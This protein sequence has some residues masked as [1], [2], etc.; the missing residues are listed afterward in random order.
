MIIASTASGA[1]IE[2][3]ELMRKFPRIGAV[4]KPAEGIRTA[5]SDPPT[6]T[7]L[8][9]VGYQYLVETEQPTPGPGEQVRRGPNQLI[10]G[11][12]TQTWQTYTPPVVVPESV[13]AHQ[14]YAALED[15]GAMPAVQAYIYGADER[16]KMFFEKA[17]Y[18]RRDAA[19]IE[20]GRIA[21]GWS[22]QQVN[23]LFIAAAALTP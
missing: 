8:A 15:M 14:F 3:Q 18:F 9:S 7:Q 1:E 4:A 22:H 23:Q 2:L 21:L 5:W 17:P 16:T 20:A 6:A 12:W 19:G 13:P 10:E 11:R